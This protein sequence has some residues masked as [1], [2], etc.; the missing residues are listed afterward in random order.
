[1][2]RIRGPVNGY[3]VASYACQVGDMGHEYVGYTKLCSARPASFWDAQGEVTYGDGRF[4]DARTAMDNSEA[5][6]LRVCAH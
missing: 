3:Y 6:A 1:M 4:S 5:L 2:E